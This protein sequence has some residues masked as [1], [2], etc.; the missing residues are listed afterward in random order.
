MGARKRIEGVIGGFIFWGG[1]PKTLI[2][3]TE[4]IKKPTHI[5][6]AFENLKGCRPYWSTP[7]LRPQMDTIL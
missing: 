5:L 2:F 1:T 6:L 4:I 7:S 3:I